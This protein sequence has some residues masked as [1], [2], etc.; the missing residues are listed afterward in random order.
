MTTFPELCEVAQQAGLEIMRFYR[1]GA[2]VAVKT[3]ISRLPPAAAGLRRA[4]EL[5]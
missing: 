1:N 5:R 2:A 4:K 3:D